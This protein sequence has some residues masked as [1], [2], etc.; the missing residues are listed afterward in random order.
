MKISGT[1]IQGMMMGA[2]TDKTEVSVS[3][4]V[5]A[6]CLDGTVWELRNADDCVLM[7]INPTA[8]LTCMELRETLSRAI[9]KSNQAE[10]STIYTQSG[11]SD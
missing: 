5:K 6:V 10:K 8:A 2:W 3:D 7:T 11:I 9:E 1:E 4:E